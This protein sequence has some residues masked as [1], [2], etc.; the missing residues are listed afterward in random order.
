[1][2]SRFKLKKRKKAGVLCAEIIT[3]AKITVLF[4]RSVWKQKHPYTILSK[5]T[6]SISFQS[7]YVST[8]DNILYELVVFRHI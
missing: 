1:M 3:C 8:T 4:V 5:L 6:L 2:E 7:K